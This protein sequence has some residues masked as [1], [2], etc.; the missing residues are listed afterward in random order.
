MKKLTAALMI[1]CLL[2]PCAAVQ[3]ETYSTIPIAYTVGGTKLSYISDETDWFQYDDVERADLNECLRIC[4]SF[5]SYP[6]RYY[7][8]DAEDLEDYLLITPGAP[9]GALVIYSPAEKIMGIQLIDN[10]NFVFQED[11]DKRLSII[12]EDYVLPAGINAQY[13]LPQFY[14]VLS[15]GKDAIHQPS[16][17]GLA[18]EV[19]YVFDGQE[20]W[21]ES[22]SNVDPMYLELY[23]MYLYVFNFDVQV[24]SF[25]AADDDTISTVVLHYTN[26][27]AEVIVTYFA[28]GSAS[29]YYKPGISYYLLSGSEMNQVFGN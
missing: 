6:Y 19:S 23:T 24:D 7:D 3:A 15:I 13:V 18:S 17:Q 10:V 28:S 20:C 12:P 9:L 5:G 29:V 2:L 26:D 27:E 4:A 21:C 16:W 22:Y 1:L 25:M 14:Q 11:V 8:P